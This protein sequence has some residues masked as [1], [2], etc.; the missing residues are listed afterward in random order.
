MFTLSAQPVMSVTAGTGFIPEL[1]KGIYSLL[2]INAPIFVLHPAL[3]LLPG[4]WACGSSD[5]R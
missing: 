1:K 3:R 5:L 4:A 2:G